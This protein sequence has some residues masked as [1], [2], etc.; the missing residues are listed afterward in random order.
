MNE[1]ASIVERLK[2]LKLSGMA[3]A[4]SDIIKL[5]VQMRPSLEMA[6]SK[7]LETEIRCRDDSRTTRLLKE[8]KLRYQVLVEDITCS[9]ARNFT[10]EQLTSIA[11]CGFVRRGENLLITGLTGC[12]KSYLACALGHQ[13]CTL[14]L[15]TLY[16]NM[17]RFVDVLKQ[18]R[19]DGTFSQMLSRLDKNDLI[20]LDD[21]GLQKMDSDTRIALLTLLEE[22]YE[23]KSMIIMSQ[24]PLDKWYDYIAE[25]TLADAIMDRLINSSH[26]L[27]LEGPSLRKRKNK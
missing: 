20:V 11:D 7:M 5:P 22:R 27:N 4:V 14:G 2:A 9:T 24:L 13:A 19:L 6:L 1:L 3:E 17:N 12:G 18:S 21:F 10:R 26:H 8:S 16:L 23:K 15:K 25:A